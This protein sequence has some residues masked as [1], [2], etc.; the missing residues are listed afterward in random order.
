MA[1][2][3]TLKQLQ[4]RVIRTIENL[5][6]SEFFEKIPDVIRE[7]TRN[8]YGITKNGGEMTTLPKLKESTISRRVSLDNQGRLSNKTAPFFSNLTES[9]QMLDD[10]KFIKVKKTYTIGW[11][12]R[13]KRNG[14][15]PTELKDE[16]EK[17]GFKFFGLTAD[18]RKTLEEQVFKKIEKEI[19]K[20]FR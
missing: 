9:G 17:K 15:S 16:L 7:R 3:E 1:A 5:E 13:R 19:K 18:E 20:I 4:A 14:L 10:L 11:D 2:K 12:E 8:G 6:A